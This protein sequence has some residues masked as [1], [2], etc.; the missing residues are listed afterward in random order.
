[1]AQQAAPAERFDIV[2]AGAGHN[3]L[4]CAAYLAK[5][6]FTR[7]RAGGA[8]DDWRRLQDRRGMPRGFKEDLCSSCT[9][10]FSH[11]LLRDNELNL[12]DYG[13]EYIDP[14]PI[15]YTQFADGSPSRFGRDMDRTV[16]VRQDLEEG[17]GDLPAIVPEFKAYSKLRRPIVPA[18]LVLT[19]LG[20]QVFHIAASGNVDSNVRL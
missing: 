10:V 2:V 3:S 6:V 16:R 17:C 15:L 8:S 11:P 20:R 1:M 4:V 7:S 14:D 18:L 12:R 13:L 5:A 9:R 19:R